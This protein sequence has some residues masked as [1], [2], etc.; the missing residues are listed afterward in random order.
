MKRY[1]FI[2]IDRVNHLTKYPTKEEYKTLLLKLRRNIIFNL[3]NIYCYE[4]KKDKWLHYHGIISSNFYLKY[5][6]FKEKGY[7]IKLIYC[8]TTESLLQKIRY[9]NKNKIDKVDCDISN[10]QFINNLASL[11]S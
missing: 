10:S 2:T 1:Y 7:S 11:Y 9:I 6:D 5:T 3:E 4:Y 8:K